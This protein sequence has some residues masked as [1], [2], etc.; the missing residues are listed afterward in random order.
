MLGHNVQFE[1]RITKLEDSIKSF[2]V[3]MCDQDQQIDNIRQNFP[4][5]EKMLVKEDI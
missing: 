2:V 1:R 5:N 4:K 3:Q